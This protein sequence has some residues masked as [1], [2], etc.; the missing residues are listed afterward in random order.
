MIDGSEK[1][2]RQLAFGL[3]NWHVC[4]KRSKDKNI[5]FSSQYGFRE[6]F[7]TEQAIVDIVSA[8]QSNMDKHLFTRGIFIDL[9][10]AFDTVNHQILP[11]KFN[12]YGFRGIIN[13]CFESFLCH[14]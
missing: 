6:G 1:R 3:Q 5:L 11:N 8:I 9:K 2:N 12:R 4:E 14:G 7:S 13:S 10:K